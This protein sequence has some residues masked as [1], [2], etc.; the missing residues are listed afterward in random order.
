LYYQIEN[1]KMSNLVKQSI[2]I[3]LNISV[4]IEKNLLLIKGPLGQKTITLLIKVLIDK[5]K[6]EIFITDILNSECL[7]NKKLNNKALQG[8]TFA[9]IKQHFLGVSIGFRKQLNIVG[10]GYRAFIENNSNILTL[11]LGY[12]HPVMITIPNNLKIVCLKP[13]VISIF[14]ID[15]QKVNEMAA[16][17]KSYKIPEPYK[18]KGI[19]YQDE[20]II[21]KEG[22]RS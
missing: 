15:K 10:V 18:G 4:E 12:S 6:K 7:G 8:S 19:I 1:F 2:K 3:P 17:I 21:R 16:K 5:N 13:T 14:G 11:K 22:K 9:L 20:K